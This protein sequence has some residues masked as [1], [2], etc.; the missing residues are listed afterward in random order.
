MHGTAA[1]RVT[2]YPR[3]TSTAYKVNKVPPQFRTCVVP[4]VR[5]FCGFVV[6]RQ[7][8]VGSGLWV[9]VFGQWA[10]PQCRSAAVPQWAVP[11]CRRA[12][13]PQCRS[14]AV[15]SAAVPQ[16]RSAAVPQC[17]SAAALELDRNNGKS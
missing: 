13:V 14:A 8:F 7:W 10:V 9:V 12:A 4:S 1:A 3:A 6:C 2:P 17:C 16:C 5:V 15:G 11:Q